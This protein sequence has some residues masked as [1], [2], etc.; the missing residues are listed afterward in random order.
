[1]RTAMIPSSHR[2]DIE[3]ILNQNQRI[4]DSRQNIVEKYV[5]NAE[6][7]SDLL[8]VFARPDPEPARTVVEDEEVR[9][10]R[11]I[12]RDEEQ[13]FLRAMREYESKAD[14]KHK[15]NLNLEGKHTMEEVWIELDAAVEKYEKGE[16]HKAGIWGKVRRA[17]RK[18]GQHGKAIEEWLGLV[19]SEPDYLS[20]AAVKLKDIREG[21][22]NGIHDIP[23]LLNGTQRVLGVYRQSEK[24]QAHSDG[25]YVAVLINLGHSLRY[26][27]RRVLPKTLEATLKGA[28]FEQALTESL[29]EV[30]KRR[31]EF[32]EEA[33]MCGVEMAG[34]LHAMVRQGN[35]NSCKITELQSRILEG[36]AEQNRA[37]EFIQKQVVL[38]HEKTSAMR[39]TT[40]NISRGVSGLRSDLDVHSRYIAE[41]MS[42][43]LDLLQASPEA[44]AQAVAK[45]KFFGLSF[46]VHYSQDDLLEKILKG[47]KYY[48]D[49]V[50]ADLMQNYALAFTLPIA[51]QDRC[52]WL[53]KSIKLAGWLRSPFSGIL[54][55]NGNQVKTQR[56]SALSFVAS[57]LART[58]KNVGQMGSLDEFPIAAL[59]F[60]CGEHFDRAD[61]LNSAVSVM[62]SLLGQLL[63]SFGDKIDLMELV[64]LGPL[65]TNDLKALCVRFKIVLRLLP[66]EAVVF[67]IIDNFADFL[68][69]DRTSDEAQ[70][71]LR[72]FIHLMKHQQ[73]RQG[74]CVFKLLLTSSVRFNVLEVSR[75]KD[76]EKLDVP[77]TVPQT[78]GFTQMKWEMGLGEQAS[79]L[80]SISDL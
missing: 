50:A 68:S 63:T 80:V 18:L 79:K 73:K 71:L 10:R 37:Q 24:L 27:R 75:M 16:S 62:D 2:E 54:I 39:D 46:E 30:R 56:R 65:K 42:L 6:H 74:A 14:D 47:M 34:E 69:S 64:Q 12:V 76:D 11:S 36:Q 15:T 70:S 22:L 72:W 8:A 25:L 61:P 23:V 35:E 7:G 43:V 52:V 59:H 67:C 44:Y 5:T 9:R 48:P 60:F 58:L 66:R 55:V 13:K 40:E 3:V 28:S 41:K 53:I 77:Q 31:N 4:H 38:M 26:V 29:E 57:R 20:T 1:M 49:Q 17:F 19:P 32:N 78:G 21:L 33:R 45:R 51:D